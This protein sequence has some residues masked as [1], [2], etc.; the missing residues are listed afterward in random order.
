[1]KIIVSGYDSLNDK[2]FEI[3]INDIDLIKVE[4]QPDDGIYVVLD[5]GELRVRQNAFQIENVP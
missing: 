2:D 5:G 4:H 1:M 3:E